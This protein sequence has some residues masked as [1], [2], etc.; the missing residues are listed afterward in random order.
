MEIKTKR[1]LY[2][3]VRPYYVSG[4]PRSNTVQNKHLL[5]RYVFV[6]DVISEIEEY[7][8]CY[9][10]NQDVIDIGLALIKQLKQSNN[11]GSEVQDE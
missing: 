10:D 6:D 7:I 5:K 3:E 1:E 9:K 4:V 11:Y 2:F 8:S